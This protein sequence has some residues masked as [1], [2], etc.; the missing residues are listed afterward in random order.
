MR[1]PEAMKRMALS[2]GPLLADVY[3]IRAIQHYGDTKRSTERAPRATRCCIRCS[4]SRPRS[5]PC[6]T[7][8][9]TFGAIFLAEPAPGG[10]GRP[11]QAIALLQ[12]GLKAQ[13]DNWRLM[14]ALGFVHYWWHEDYRTAAYWFDQAAKRPGAPIWM[15]PLAAVTL[16]QGGNR[17]CL[18]A[19]VAA[20]R[21][22]PSP[23]SGFATRRARR[24]QQLDALDQMDALESPAGGLPARGPAAR[25]RGWADLVRAG[26]AARH[27][28]R[29]ERPAVPDRTGDAAARSRVAAAAAAGPGEA[30]MI[31]ARGA[32]GLMVGSFL[33]V[34]I[35]RLPRRESVA[36]P[37]SHCTSCRRR[38]VVVRERA[39][40]EL[41][42][43]A[44]PVPQLPGADQ[45]PVSD[46][47]S[48][49]RRALRR[50]RT[51]GTGRRRSASSGTLFGCAMI[52]LF[53]IDLQHRILPN[54]DHR[55]GHRRSAWC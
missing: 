12:K 51:T 34:C 55:A 21:R 50:R 53:V 54:V 41:A 26:P 32:C 6:S 49:D 13:P 37:A 25:P 44:R 46:R 27:A 19:D 23:T 36:W 31:A 11:D 28:A 42:G 47:R 1:S 39:G 22:R 24:L 33:N 17:A 30:A 38:A 20:R 3:W 16:A 7:S 15:A 18:A 45:R 14:Q 40:G 8:P 29:P 9:I 2:Y 4:T 48:R 10:P 35:Y 5:I 43:A 52:V